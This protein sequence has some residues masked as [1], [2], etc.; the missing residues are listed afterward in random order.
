MKYVLFLALLGSAFPVLSEGPEV[1]VVNQTQETLYEL[2]V[3]PS[4]GRAWGQD[5]LGD[6]VLRSGESVTVPIKAAGRFD[7]MA[8][9][10]ASRQ[11]Y[12]AGEELTAGRTLRVTAEQR[13][14]GGNLPSATD[15]GWIRI[16]N[17]TGFVIHYIYV[18]PGYASSWEEGEQVL[19]EDQV[20][21]DGDEY[22]VE[23]DL[24][25]YRTAVF[26]FLLIDE[27]RDQY[28]K[29]DVDIS[30]VAMLGFSLEDIQWN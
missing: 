26:D 8:I 2:Y 19:P 22:L 7:V 13:Y 27:D 25:K 11:Y 5:L 6:G 14:D 30:D 16:H 17:E 1:T 3:S 21:A 28:V 9:D 20:L 29:W 15:F 18:S 24:E 23:I 4:A 12:L 10:E